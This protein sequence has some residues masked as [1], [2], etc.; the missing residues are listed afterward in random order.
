MTDGWWLLCR[1]E[2]ERRPGERSEF[3]NP[4]EMYEYLEEYK[5]SN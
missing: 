5:G 3:E 2:L 4:E 1:M